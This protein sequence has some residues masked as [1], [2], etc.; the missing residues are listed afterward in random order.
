[1]QVKTLLITEVINNLFYN[2][3]F[4]KIKINF[5]KILWFMAIER[6]QFLFPYLKKI[7]SVS[8][9][10]VI[11]QNKCYNVSYNKMK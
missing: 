3:Q 8:K 2:R 1:M 5:R 11:F 6:K 4:A 7:I 9:S 10:I